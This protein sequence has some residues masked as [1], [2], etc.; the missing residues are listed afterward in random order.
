[1]TGPD[2]IAPR[3]FRASL[4]RIIDARRV[5]TPDVETKRLAARLAIVVIGSFVV[6]FCFAVWFVG[7]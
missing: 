1:M 4:E 3:G 6:C 7:V 5:D 2:Y